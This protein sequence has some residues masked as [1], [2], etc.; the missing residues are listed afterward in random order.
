[1]FNPVSAKARAISPGVTVT[2]RIIG[3][4]E[5]KA[6]LIDAGLR[7]VWL[8]DDRNVDQIVKYDDLADISAVT[9]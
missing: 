6:R 3:H 1:M 7:T 2:V 4:A 5:Y 9:P 8:I